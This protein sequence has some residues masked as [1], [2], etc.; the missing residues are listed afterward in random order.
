MLASLR[1]SRIVL[2]A[3]TLAALTYLATFV[4]WFSA[5]ATLSI[6]VRAT[7][8]LAT[9]RPGLWGI[10]YILQAF[11]FILWILV[12]FSI[13]QKYR[14]AAPGIS[15]LAVI[16]GGFGFAWRALTDFA[17]AGSIEYLGQL[18]ASSDPAMRIMAEQMASWTQ[19]WT[20]GAVWEFMGN[21]IAFGIF[22]FTIGLI[23]VAARQRTLGWILALLGG[24]AG[25]SFIGGAVYYVAGIR[26]GLNIILVP[27][28]LAL[29]TGPLWLLWFAWLGDR[30]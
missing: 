21:G 7:L 22:P 29:A 28:F 26:T 14:A 6:T 1:F 15:Q 13:S 2:V 27:G 23:L 8:E 9:Q 11:A 25:L 10:G 30:D 5:G 24:L 20:F 17:R 19:L 16:V 12:P 4:L 18:Y 3:A